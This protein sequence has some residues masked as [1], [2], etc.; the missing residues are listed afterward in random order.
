MT[1]CLICGG[2]LPVVSGLEVRAGVVVSDTGMTV[3]GPVSTGIIRA[4]STGPLSTEQLIDL[5]YGHADDV[6]EWPA[7]SLHV[8]IHKLRE[9]L[10]TIGWTIENRG[11]GFG[12][13]SIYTLERVT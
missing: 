13:G 1:G 4:L 11:I 7:G 5:V 6:P 9:R 8:M 12:G 10:P 3:F 2:P